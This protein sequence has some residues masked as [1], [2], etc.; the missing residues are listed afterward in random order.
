MKPK[1]KYCGKSCCY[2]H[3][4][5][6]PP[7]EIWNDGLDDKLNS[8]NGFPCLLLLCFSATTD[9][10]IAIAVAVAILTN[11]FV[12]IFVFIFFCNLSIVVAVVV[13]VVCVVCNA[14]F[15]ESSF[16]K[17]HDIKC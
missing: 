17:L 8:S 4:L 13:A 15:D 10:A 11:A 3:S 9:T 7:S 1:S 14:Y 6:A 12:F 2:K 16:L 5:G